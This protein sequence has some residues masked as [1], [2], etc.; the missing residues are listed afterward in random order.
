MLLQLQLPIGTSLRVRFANPTPPFKPLPHSL[1]SLPLCPF[2]LPL[3]PPAGRISREATAA[4]AATSGINDIYP[5][6]SH[7]HTPS[8][9]HTVCEPHFNRFADVFC[10]VALI[11]D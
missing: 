1:L 8:S 9:T 5:S 10:V 3:S 7:T 11:F 4:A 6:A 2:R